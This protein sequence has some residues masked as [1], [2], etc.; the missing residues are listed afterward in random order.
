M[1]W[2][3][4]ADPYHI[5]LS[6]IILQQTRVEQGLPYFERFVATYPTVTDLARA[7]DDAVMKLWEGL[8]YYSRARNLLRAARHVADRLDSSFPDTYAGLLELPGVG[9]L[10]RRC[11]CFLWLRSPGRRARRQRLPSARPLRRRRNAHRYRGCPQALSITGRPGDGGGRR[12]PLQPGH[13]GLRG[14][15]LHSPAG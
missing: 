6:E 10:H 7:P 2:K 3:E 11:H 5:W 15:G 14:A 12:G 9:A 13:Y 4:A 1:P 8:G